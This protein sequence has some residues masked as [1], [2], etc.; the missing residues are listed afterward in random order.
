MFK[1]VIL[2]GAVALTVTLGGCSDDGDSSDERRPAGADSGAPSAGDGAPGGGSAVRKGPAYTG[3]ALPGLT[4]QPRW[5]VAG[6]NGAGKV[7]TATGTVTGPAEARIIGNTVALVRTELAANTPKSTP[8]PG[9]NTIVGDWN[10]VELRDPETG[11]VRATANLRGRI[12]AGTWAGKPVLYAVYSEQTASDGLSTAK[13]TTVWLALDEHGREVGKAALPEDNDADTT[14]TVV[15][16]WLVSTVRDGSRATVNVRPAGGGSAGATVEQNVTAF[17]GGKDLQ[18]FGGMLFSRDKADKDDVEHL[19]AIDIATGQRK[20]TTATVRKPAGTPE[21]STTSGHEPEIVRT[22]GGDK[23]VIAWDAGSKGS[24][25][26]ATQWGLYDLATGNLLHEGPRITSGYYRWKVDREESLMLIAA[27]T[28]AE[29]RTTAWDLKTGR[30]LWQQPKE[31]E[32]PIESFVVVNGALYASKRGYSPSGSMNGDNPRA[33][34]PLVV[35]ARTKAVV[36][37]EG[38]PGDLFPK[39]T[40]DGHGV[41]TTKDGIFVFGPKPLA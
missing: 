13:R 8:S 25:S 21:A 40:A 14:E 2:A 24:F 19:V 28:G 12:I 17:D 30:I 31:G 4:D 32:L 1:S 33:T 18:V 10:T 36:L 27:G 41:V 15:D 6:S 38:V 7:D 9:G 20:W 39:M 26:F 5:S 16:G 11:A 34:E 35:D 23:I 3:P 37:P 22:V 29:V